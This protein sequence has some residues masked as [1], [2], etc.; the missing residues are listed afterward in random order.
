MP[1]PSYLV[2]VFDTLDHHVV[3]SKLEYMVF[4]ANPLMDLRVT[5]QN[6]S[7]LSSLKKKTCSSTQQIKC[8][9]PQ[10]SETEADSTIVPVFIFYI[11]I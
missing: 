11:Q 6:M 9:V 3:F 7:S 10:G 1:G 2:P 4:A 5:F 8:V